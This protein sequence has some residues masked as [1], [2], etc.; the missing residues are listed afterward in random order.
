MKIFAIRH[1]QTK[2]NKQKR[3]NG[4]I[5]EPLISEGIKQ[6]KQAVSLIPDSTKYIYSSP[7]KRTVQTAQILNAKL[8]LPL[9]FDEGIAE[10]HMG[11][12]AGK[13][14]EEM[15][16]GEN[17][18]KKHR[19]IQFDYR[20]HGGES[21][22]EVKK[23][24]IKFL[25]EIYGKHKDHKALIVTHGGIIRVLHFLETGEELLDDIENTSIRTVDLS[26]IL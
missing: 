18:K 4:Q 10:I 13:S 17:F 9:I 6:A 1:G 5:D 2:L 7:L 26:K 8:N 12:L 15:E 20:K 25:K 3:V 22:E 16:Q 14:W 24:V 19:S 11:S 23:R 21:A